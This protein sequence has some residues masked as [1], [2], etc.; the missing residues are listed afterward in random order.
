MVRGLWISQ[1]EEYLYSR[2]YY[3]HTRCTT[4]ESTF[5]NKHLKEGG[6]QKHEKEIRI[7][8]SLPYGIRIHN[9]SRCNIQLRDSGFWREIEITRKRDKEEG[10]REKEARIM[11]KAKRTDQDK[12]AEWTRFGVTSFPS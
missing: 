5:R 12:P 10:G 9:R 3:I 2:V 1:A 11:H 7:R 6:E 4:N 8:A